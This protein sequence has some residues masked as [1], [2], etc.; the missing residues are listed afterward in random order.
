MVLSSSSSSRSERGATR[1]A[2]VTR[3]CLLILAAGLANACS[4]QA[5]G[6]APAPAAAD[7]PRGDVGAEGAAAENAATSPPGP[8]VKVPVRTKTGVRE[9]SAEVRGGIAYYQGDIDLGDPGDMKVRSLGMSD[10]DLR[11][12]GSRVPYFFDGVSSANEADI[13]SAMAHIE[14][15][16]RI[17][18]VET[19]A[20]VCFTGGSAIRFVPSTDPGVSSSKVGRQGGCQTLKFWANHDRGVAIH[21][22]GHALGLKHEQS[23]PDRNQWVSV[24]YANIDDD[25]EDNF[26]MMDADDVLETLSPYD[27]DSVMHYRRFAFCAR[28]WFFNT[29]TG[30]MDTRCKGPTMT[31]LQGGN[32]NREFG[33]SVLTPHD[34]NMLSLM[35]GDPLGSNEAGDSM[36]TSVVVADFDNDG[37][38]DIVMGAPRE[39]V[40]T[41][42]RSGAVYTFKGTRGGPAPWEL[43]TEA[44]VNEQGNAIAVDEADDELGAAMVSADFDNDGFADL[45][46][47]APNKAPGSGSR[48][49]GVMTFRGTAHGLVAWQYVTL[50][51]TGRSGAAGDRFGASL[52]TIRSTNGA[53]PRLVVGAPGRGTAGAA[54]VVKLPISDYDAVPAELTLSSSAYAAKLGTSL[55]VGDYDSDGNLDIA[56]GAP[57][58]GSSGA[59]A[60][61][62]FMGNGNSTFTRLQYIASPSG[63]SGDEFGFAL[64]N[65]RTGNGTGT[66]L[67]VGAP[68]KKQG[69]VR[70]GAAFR[71]QYTVGPALSG[72]LGVQDIYPGSATQ[73]QRFGHALAQG[74]LFGSS[75]PELLVG[76]PGHSS[77]AGRVV[78]MAPSG[79]NL[80][81]DREMNVSASGGSR[82]G[83]SIAVGGITVYAANDLGEAT[84]NPT[85]FVGAPSDSLMPGYSVGGRVY[86][87]NTGA[88]TSFLR[89][90]LE[91]ESS[92][93]WSKN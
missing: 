8:R 55:A 29:S 73:V 5:E 25:R 14:R 4:S 91:Q 67:V 54:Y 40:A 35:Y 46:V 93:P 37:R 72:M 13:R 19:E 83:T 3:T 24:N 15:R 75:L 63:A 32:P 39:A 30:L 56:V 76:A 77:G 1:R 68:G 33:G 48:S 7:V 47:G 74:Q 41:G 78:V 58:A 71:Y 64:A 28:E 81:Y 86:G 92:T 20:S 34:I 27:Y 60:V 26:D 70:T 62:L 10:E 44:T 84:D 65:A 45:A 49:G 52:A 16:T 36:G 21:E 11:W 66:E 22:I 87:Y 69:S 51:N 2:R 90:S 18:F 79:G 88:T 53:N 89:V 43:L 50:N 9:I 57:A 23:R 61:Q 17:R 59:G 82:F 38:N 42:P 85:F 80:A 12:V 6:E 31:A